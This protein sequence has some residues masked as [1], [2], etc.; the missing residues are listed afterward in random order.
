MYKDFKKSG[1]IHK[2]INKK[3]KNKLYDGIS[4]LEL[5][6]FI[7]NEIKLYTK[8]DLNNPLEAGIGFPVG[9]SIN[10]K[11]RKKHVHSRLM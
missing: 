8:F 3:I 10:D 2:V 5:T 1:I 7:E 6:E 9:I 4:A 11:C